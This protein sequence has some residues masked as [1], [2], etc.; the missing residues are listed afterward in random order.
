[1]VLVQELGHVTITYVHS[2]IHHMAKSQ[3]RLVLDPIRGR[4]HIRKCLICG[5]LATQEGCGAK[6]YVEFNHDTN[7]VKVYHLGNHK[8]AHLKLDKGPTKGISNE[9]GSAP[10]CREIGKRNGYCRSLQLH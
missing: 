2:R 1:M 10:V 5:D 8:C 6:K 3:T 7:R 9:A 4:K